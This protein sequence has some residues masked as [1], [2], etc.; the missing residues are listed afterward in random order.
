MKTFSWYY[1]AVIY[2]FGYGGSEQV[3]TVFALFSVLILL[4]P[5]FFSVCDG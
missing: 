1:E 4:A 5:Y 3:G 2:H